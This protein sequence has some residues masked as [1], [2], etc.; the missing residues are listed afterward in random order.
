MRVLYAGGRKGPMREVHA[1]SGYWSQ[2]GATQVLGRAAEPQAIWI[3][4]PDG[5][6]ETVT[7]KNSEWDI[8]VQTHHAQR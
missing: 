8:H 5:K 1:G 4:W 2:D 3:R 7:I 6:E